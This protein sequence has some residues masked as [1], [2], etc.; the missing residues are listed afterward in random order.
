MQYRILVF[1]CGSEIGLEIHNALKFSTHVKLFGG[2]T[3]ANHGK[4][5]YKNYIEDIPNVDSFD[6]IEGINKILDENKIDF[7][8]PAHDSVVLKLAENIDKLSCSVIG[9][10]A[11]TC[12]ICRSKSKTYDFFKGI[13][14]VPRIYRN[15][16]SPSKYPIFLKP[17]I[18]QGSKGTFLVNSLEE[19]EFYKKKDESILVLEYLPGEEYTIDCFTN[20]NG[21]LLYAEAR[22][23]NR[24]S[25][26][27]SVETFP[28]KESIFK[29]IAE[30]I[31]KKLIF[32]GVW[33]F[34][35]KKDV[36][37]KY[38]LLEIAPRIAGSMALH[39][40]LGINFALLS[41][42]DA[43]NKEVMISNNKYDIIM[44]RALFNRFQIKL[45]YNSVYIDLDDTIIFENKVNPMVLF[46]LYQCLNDGIKV[47]L[48]SR[49][50]A[51]T[52][53]DIR[54]ILK[55]FKIGEIFDEIIDVMNNESKDIYIRD[56][57]SIFI[58]D[59]FSERRVVG[60][61]LDIPTFE[62]SSIESLINWKY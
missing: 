1:P 31:N 22:R 54:D 30:K 16:E 33:F 48:L 7:I 28:I 11:K 24:V 19:I 21:E 47:C 10:P 3:I 50:K 29:S 44:D 36:D 42:F 53:N 45:E 39:R 12:E 35:L 9:S 46:Y 49:H 6:F 38:V 61:K 62:V 51:R 60:D 32:R 5:V 15:G 52:G 58:D 8:F 41:V 55:S 43:L 13:I 27:I 18:G 2:S 25:N 23:R 59:S 40:N 17:D 14:D 26:G 57:K 4:Y 37:G 56:K 20:K 34:Q